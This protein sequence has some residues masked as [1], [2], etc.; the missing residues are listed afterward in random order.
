MGWR[1]DYFLA[2]ERIQ[3]HILKVEHRIV[4]KSDHCPIGREKH[5]ARDTSYNP[6]EVPEDITD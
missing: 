5:E 3:N 2:S 6:C 1:L 4:T